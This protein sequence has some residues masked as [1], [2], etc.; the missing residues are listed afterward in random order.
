MLDG[1]SPRA[2]LSRLDRVVA[3]TNRGLLVRWTESSASS[4]AVSLD[5]GYACPR[6][7][8]EPK[9]RGIFR[10]VAELANTVISVERVEAPGKGLFEFHLRW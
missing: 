6:E 5:Y 3:T 9:W 4:G 10:Y 1:G 2:V 8:I 7:I